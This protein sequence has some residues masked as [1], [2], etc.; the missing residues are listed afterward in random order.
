MKIKKPKWEDGEE[1]WE[2]DWKL[3]KSWNKGGDEDEKKDWNANAKWGWNMDEEDEGL[4]FFTM[5]GGR[6]CIDWY[7]CRGNGRCYHKYGLC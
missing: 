5:C 1:D 3:W 4:D 2:K 6:D 7:R